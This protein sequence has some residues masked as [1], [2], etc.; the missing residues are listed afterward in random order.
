MVVTWNCPNTTAFSS[1]PLTLHPSF[2]FPLFLHAS[3][4]SKS[5]AASHSPISHNV[6]V[7]NQDVDI[8]ICLPWPLMPLQK[9]TRVL[10]MNYRFITSSLSCSSRIQEVLHVLRNYGLYCVDTGFTSLPQPPVLAH[11]LPTRSA[12]NCHMDNMRLP[13]WLVWAPPIALSKTQHWV[14]HRKKHLPSFSRTMP[15]LSP[16]PVLIARTNF[17][18]FTSLPDTSYYSR[19]CLPFSES[20]IPGMEWDVSSLFCRF[21]LFLKYWIKMSSPPRCLFS[22]CPPIT[23]HWRVSVSELP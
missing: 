22:L 18:S 12:N 4:L 10:I 16:E 15:I 11:S 9:V 13:G 3:G 20:Y 5:S 17:A 8:S 21:L 14:L 23:A 7:F 1:P 6:T 19:I 2:L